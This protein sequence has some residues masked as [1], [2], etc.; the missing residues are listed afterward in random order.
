MSTETTL[1]DLRVRSTQFRA[2][3]QRRA[4]VG[5]SGMYIST[6]RAPGKGRRMVVISANKA[7]GL[8]RVMGEPCG[9][10]VKG[11]VTAWCESADVLRWCDAVDRLRC[12]QP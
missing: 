11:R 5:C 12:E 1:H 8:P 2:E 10:G 9:G 6:P 4:S 7:L 3:C